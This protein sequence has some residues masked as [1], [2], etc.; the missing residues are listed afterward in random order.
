MPPLAPPEGGVIPGLIGTPLAPEGGVILDVRV[1]GGEIEIPSNA[2]RVFHAP[3]VEEVGGVRYQRNPEFWSVW[4]YGDELY[5][6]IIF[7]EPS[8]QESATLKFSLHS[9][10]W[11]LWIKGKSD[12]ADPFEYPLD[13]LIL[14]YLTVTNK[15]IMI[16]ASGINNDGK[17]YLFSGISGQGKSTIARIWNEAGATVIHDDRLI[18]KRVGEKYKM[19]NTP[20]YDNDEPREAPIDRI[21][22]IG[23]GS[24][25]RSEPVE[26]ASAVS[27]V[28]ANCI[29]QNWSPL[30]IERL[31]GSISDLCS[32][33]P[34]YKLDFL[35]DKSVTDYIT[36]LTTKDHKG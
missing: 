19:Y 12:K 34:V 31:L 18:I 27:L 10:C 15:D 1:F 22:F 4:K 20:V 13:G 8:E 30:V 6:T 24:E 21:Y 36:K 11:E 26:G 29:Q 35:P 32:Q 2:A 28:M 3:Y 7:P 17:G 14:Y 9:S 5:I 33:V 25:N 23:H 16:H